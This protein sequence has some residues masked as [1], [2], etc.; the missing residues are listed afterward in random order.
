MHSPRKRRK[1]SSLVH[2]S[3]DASLP[4]SI[5][6]GSC[7]WPRFVFI[8]RKS[9]YERAQALREL[10]RRQRAARRKTRRD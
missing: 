9:L 2:V 1:K 6:N 5:A 3:S 8:S 10:E 7:E 4:A